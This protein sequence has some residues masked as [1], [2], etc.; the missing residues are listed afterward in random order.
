[1]PTPLAS[2]PKAAVS[3]ELLDL[4][5]LPPVEQLAERYIAFIERFIMTPKGRGANKPAV[6]LPFQKDIIRDLYADETS[7]LIVSIARGNGKSTLAAYLAVAELFAGPAVSPEIAVVASNLRQARIIYT[8]AKRIIELSPQLLERTKI[9]ADRIEVPGRD[10]VMTPYPAEPDGIHGASPVLALV[11]EMHV[12]TQELWE[13]MVSALGKVPGSKLLAISTPADTKDSIMFQLLAYG[14]DGRDPAFKVLEYGA[15]VDADPDSQETWLD[16]NPAAQGPHAFLSLKELSTLRATMRDPVFRQLRLGQW[17][18]GVNSW[19]P[20]EALMDASVPREIPEGT[21]IT[22]GFD[23]SASGDSTVLIA[24]TVDAKPHVWPIAMWEKPRD[25]DRWRVPRHEVIAKVDE[26]FEKYAVQRMHY[27]PFGW[28][29]EAEDMADKHGGRKVI[30]YATNQV[31]RMAPATD[32]FYQAIVEGNITLEDNEAF[33]QHFLNA[34]AKNTTL[35]DLITKDGS[36][37]PRKIDAA[38]AS[39]IAYEAAISQTRKKSKAAGFK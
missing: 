5:G 6:L 31:R 2:G 8:T 11:D 37:S 10:G 19:L 3:S 32:R 21:R 15:P 16:A 18:D 35:G 13:V 17:V 30:E 24:A 25:D 39:I 28:R 20:Y 1:M 12:V 4:S 27:D 34:V 23:G 14:R 29:T 26:T 7:I 9:F 38:V 36:N 33:R 22:L